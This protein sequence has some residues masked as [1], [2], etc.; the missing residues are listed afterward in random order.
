MRR[1]ILYLVATVTLFSLASCE[2]NEDIEVNNNPDN[3]PENNTGTIDGPSVEYHF[4]TIETTTTSDS[5]TITADVPYITIDGV[6]SEEEASMQ[7]GYHIYLASEEMLFVGEYE[8]G[9]DG[10]A[11]FLLEGLEHSTTYAARLYVDTPS[12]GG[13]VSPIFTFATEAPT[14]MSY[15]CRVNPQIEARGLTATVTLSNLDYCVDDISRAIQS[16]VFEY[17]IN[18]SDPQEW[19]AYECDSTTITN[20]QVRFDIPKQDGEYLMAPACYDYRIT[21]VP[22]EPSYKSITT[23]EQQ[24]YT[25]S[26]E[27]TIDISTPELS[28]WKSPSQ[29]MEGDSLVT[30]TVDKVE[31]FYDGVCSEDYRYSYGEIFY[32]CYRPKGSEDWTVKSVDKRDG[33]FSGQFMVNDPAPDTIY[34]VKAT[35]YAGRGER[36]SKDSAT[37]EINVNPSSEK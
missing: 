27:V 21:I 31:I 6:R 32:I 33:G 4:G 13:A 22:V 23:I 29:Q 36:T 25:I 8:I 35:V 10:R 1:C 24:F 3:I 7:I 28:C 19:I 37:V 14:P 30:V 5:A 9:E 17:R 18:H 2:C 16:V 15:S 11:V 12:C 34:E 20:R 26:P